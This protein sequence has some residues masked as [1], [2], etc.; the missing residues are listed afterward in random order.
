MQMMKQKN[1]DPHACII[2]TLV[3]SLQDVLVFP[4]VCYGGY[5]AKTK[6]I[7]IK[8]A[9]GKETYHGFTR[10]TTMI[11]SHQLGFV[12]RCRAGGDG[13]GG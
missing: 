13:G 7:L 4:G 5:Q 12:V 1:R 10:R 6:E 3:V 9:W 11:S 8:R 2:H